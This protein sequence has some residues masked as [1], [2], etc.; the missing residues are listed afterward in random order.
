[1]ICYKN[2]LNKNSFGECRSTVCCNP[3]ARSYSK[4]VYIDVPSYTMADTYV[5]KAN[6]CEEL[7]EELEALFAKKETPITIMGFLAT[8]EY[9]DFKKKWLN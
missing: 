2:C 4:T 8:K 7:L 1:M 5:E 9:A 6:P 3:E